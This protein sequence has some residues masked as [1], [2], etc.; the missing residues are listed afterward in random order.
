[1]G[2]EKLNEKFSKEEDTEYFQ[3]LFPIDHPKN[4]RFA[5]NFFTSIGVGALTDQ[6]R[7]HLEKQTKEALML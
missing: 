6:L 4:T 3:G 2:L 7:L 5:I 1:M